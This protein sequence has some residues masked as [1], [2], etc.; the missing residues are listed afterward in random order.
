MVFIVFSWL[1]SVFDVS[2]CSWGFGRV[3]CASKFL[4]ILMAVTC[5]D[6]VF[7]QE[8]CDLNSLHRCPGHVLV[9]GILS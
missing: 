7:C 8:F 3:V 2:L 1:G 6:V 5:F 4:G 9:F